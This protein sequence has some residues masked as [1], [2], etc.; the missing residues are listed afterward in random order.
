MPSIKSSPFGDVETETVVPGHTRTSPPRVRRRIAV[1]SP[2]VL[3]D[4]DATR[5]PV[6]TSDPDVPIATGTAAGCTPAVNAGT[7]GGLAVAASSGLMRMRRRL[8]MASQV[9]LTG[10]ARSTTTRV[11]A[12]L[13]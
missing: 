4:P 2:A 5:L 1:S 13:A 3:E 10:A 12:G 7:D 9:Y 6:S 11:T 8:P